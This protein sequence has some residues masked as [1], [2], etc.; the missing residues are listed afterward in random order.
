MVGV[1]SQQIGAGEFEIS[2]QSALNCLRHFRSITT[3]AAY[4]TIQ[5]K[6][7][8]PDEYWSSPLDF[9]AS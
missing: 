1:S 9:S 6:N 5:P 4:S 8:L 7:N 2:A 3:G